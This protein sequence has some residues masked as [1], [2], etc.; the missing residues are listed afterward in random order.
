MKTKLKRDARLLALFALIAA[1]PLAIWACGD[2]GDSTDGP[3]GPGSVY[4]PNIDYPGAT[5][6]AKANPSAVA[7]GQTF[8]I[9]ANFKDANGLPVEGV[10]L[11]V[12]AENGHADAYF[13][14]QTN[15]T[16]TDASG[17]ASIHVGVSAGC[18]NDSFT[19]VVGTYPAGPIN[20]PQA[21]GYVYVK[22]GGSG[23]PAVTDV[24]LTSPTSSV[25]LP[26]DPTF[27]ATATAT[28]SCT[29][30]FSYQAAGAGLSTGWTAAP[31][32]ASNPWLFTLDPS[33]A[34]TLTVLVAA[35]CN[36]TGIGLVSDPVNVT[37]TAAAA[38]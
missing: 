3:T 5:I 32:T 36:E 28:T 22:V 17:N 14:Y 29:V 10:P 13:T 24:T 11:G 1:L 37:V 23:G 26:N 27:I 21:R 12:W 20:G 15:P 7:P 19:F 6:T 16:L 31:L 18:P 9:L 2:A 8:G 25:V 33:T 30:R 38:P 34:G 35:Y 4:N